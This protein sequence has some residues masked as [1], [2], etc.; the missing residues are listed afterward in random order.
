MK[1]E[2]F[3]MSICGLNYIEIELCG[4]KHVVVGEINEQLSNLRILF[5]GAG[6][7]EQ[8]AVKDLFN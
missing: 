3:K 4:H 7:Q 8:S 5:Q 2:T 6:I 1:P